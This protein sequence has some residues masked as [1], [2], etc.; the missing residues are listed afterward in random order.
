[1]KIDNSLW[2]GHLDL[3]RIF[4]KQ[5]KLKEAH[6]HAQLAHEL[7]QEVQDVHLAYYNACVNIRD[8]AAALTE[9]DKFVK[10]YPDSE[11]AKK[12]QAIRDNLAKEAAAATKH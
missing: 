10:L 8:Y 2:L 9:L 7:N 3:A 5:G 1:M 12:M 4:G 6:Y 11:V